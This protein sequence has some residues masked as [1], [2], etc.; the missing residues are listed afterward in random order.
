MWVGLYRSHN[1]ILRSSSTVAV[2]GKGEEE[3]AY[4]FWET[5]VRRILIAKDECLALTP[6]TPSRS[7]NFAQLATLV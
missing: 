6:W 3:G 5:N 1:F 4:L 2:F 7:D